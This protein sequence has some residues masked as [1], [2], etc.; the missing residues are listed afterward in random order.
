MLALEARDVRVRVLQL[1]VA[2]ALDRDLARCSA[3]AHVGSHKDE[4]GRAYFIIADSLCKTVAAEILWT[5]SIFSRIEC[6]TSCVT[7]A[8][9]LSPVSF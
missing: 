6:E 7:R 3:R 4:G 5:F 8:Q 1:A 9:L 2:A